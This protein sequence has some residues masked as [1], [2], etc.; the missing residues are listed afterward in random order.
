V[1]ACAEDGRGRRTAAL[2]LQP[3]TT[4]LK[5]LRAFGLS[6]RLLGRNP[7]TKII[8]ISYSEELAKKFS[9]DCR[10][11]MQSEFYRRLFPRTELSPQKSTEIEFETTKR[12]YR[13][14][15]SIG[16]TLTG[17]GGEWLILDDPMKAEEATSERMREST[18]EWFKHSARSRLDNQRQ[19]KIRLRACAPLGATK[20]QVKDVVVRFC[21]RTHKAFICRRAVASALNLAFPLPDLFCLI[22][23]VQFTTLSGAIDLSAVFQ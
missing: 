13:L 19:D 21:A 3:A 20:G 10:A 14:A 7:S 5:V 4:Q 23:G 1:L 2:Y 6:A 8:C 22:A 17:R 11:L 9:R 15:T 12:G 16:G 18:A